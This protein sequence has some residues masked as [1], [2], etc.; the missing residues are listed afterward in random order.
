[1]YI[2]KCMYIC[3]YVY[4]SAYIREHS[5]SLYATSPTTQHLA[6]IMSPLPFGTIDIS[7][8]PHNSFGFE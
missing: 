4:I 1:M 2:Y 6:T 7:L 8:F 3:I 5:Y